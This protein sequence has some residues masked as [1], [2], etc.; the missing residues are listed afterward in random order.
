M[1]H[2]NAAPA[3]RSGGGRRRTAGPRRSP[4]QQAVG[5][6]FHAQQVRL[7]LLKVDVDAKHVEQVCGGGRRGRALKQLLA[8]R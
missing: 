6:R 8:A 1:H 5:E 2:R 7:A 3:L 4:V